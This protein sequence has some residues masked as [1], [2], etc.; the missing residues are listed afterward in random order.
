MARSCSAAARQGLSLEQLAA[1]GHDT[2]SLAGRFRWIF[3]AAMCLV[4]SWSFLLAMEERPLKTGAM[5]EGE[6]SAVPAE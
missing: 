5:R 4:V 1:A 6:L 2:A 3:A